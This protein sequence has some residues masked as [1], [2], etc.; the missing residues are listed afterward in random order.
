ML[1]KRG[2]VKR[3]KKKRGSGGGGPNGWNVEISISTCSTLIST[4]ERKSLYVYIWLVT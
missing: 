2:R 4:N 1:V 3:G